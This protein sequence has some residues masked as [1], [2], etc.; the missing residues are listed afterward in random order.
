MLHA[1]YEFR[2]TTAAEPVNLRTVKRA[3]RSPPQIVVAGMHLDPKGR[4]PDALLG[5]AWQG[6][7]RAAAAARRAGACVAIV[8]AAWEESE[9]DIHGVPCSFMRPHR[10][11]ERVAAWSPDVVH[12][13]GLVFPR[14]VRRLAAALPG[15]PILA[16]DH[17]TR[18]PAGWRRWWLRHGFAPLAG[19]AFTARQQAEPFVR[20][21]VLRRDLPIFEV[22]EVSNSFTPG[23]QDAA[24][25]ATRM[26]GDPCLF[27]A[28][29][30]D[31][32]KDP[33]TVLEAVAQLGAA[34]PGLRL[35]MSFRAAPLL[36]A[37]RARIT[38][39]ARLA[40][41]V[42]LL[43]EL[44][45]ADIE[46]HFRAADF[47]IQASHVESCSAAVIEALACGTTPLVTDIPSFRRITR[48]GRF[49]ALCPVADPVA[50]AAAIG[51]W[52]ARDRRGLRDQAREHFERELSFDAMGQQLCAAYDAL[53]RS[54]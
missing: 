16:Q 52:S 24:R 23:D 39:D 1:A 8:Q 12:F 47:L 46:S 6:F 40:D 41:R 45:H 7:G 54:L 14:Q 25:R 44:P 38:S 27:W 22:V 32:N 37:V 29:N 26:Q 21:G 3:P 48:D 31:A 17:G 34:L 18:C 2:L 51:D 13:E 49:G 9:R 4:G 20:A 11:L 53:V 15:V 19:V 50:F 30:L 10:L 33:L 28:G 42:R 43:D 35:Y 5:S 36:D